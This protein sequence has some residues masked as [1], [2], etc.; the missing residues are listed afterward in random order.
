[1][2]SNNYFTEEQWEAIWFINIIMSYKISIDNETKA[3]EVDKIR[4]TQ[5]EDMKDIKQKLDLIMEHLNIKE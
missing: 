3:V 4:R 1:M 5:L 2:A